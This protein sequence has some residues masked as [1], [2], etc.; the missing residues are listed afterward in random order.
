[1]Y[2][3]AANPDAYVSL[4]VSCI[5]HCLCHLCCKLPTWFGFMGWYYTTCICWG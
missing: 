5:N 4:Q 1:M 2:I 3:K